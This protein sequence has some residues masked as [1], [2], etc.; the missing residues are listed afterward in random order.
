MDK[1]TEAPSDAASPQSRT[2]WAKVWDA[3]TRLFH[4]GIVLLVA[5]SYITARTGR[6]DWHFYSGY[7]ILT[8]VLFRIGWGFAGSRTARF[9][10]F[11]RG[12]QAALAHLAD[13]ARRHPESGVG[14]NAAGGLMVALLLLLLLAQATSGLFANDGLFEA[15]PLAALVGPAWSDRIS[16]LHAFMVN[17]LLAAIAIHVAAVLLYAT[18]LRQ[19]IVRPMITGW[20]KLPAGSQA[21]EITPWWRAGAMVA[22]AAAI[23]AWVS[24]LG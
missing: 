6:I 21:P 14:H 13:V 20:K 23:V 7:A 5:T 19:D 8:L 22:V 10:H 1:T 2:R 24:R 11:I 15:G 3:P 9:S 12:P 4:W 16:G 17:L 18:V